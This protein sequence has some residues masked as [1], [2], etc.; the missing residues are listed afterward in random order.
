MLF[1]RLSTLLLLATAA[2]AQRRVEFNRDVRPILSDKC[3]LCHGPDAV[4]RKIPLRLDSEAAAK[5]DLGNRRAIVE[6]NPKLSGL[7]HRITAEKTA[8]RM[9]P[10]YSGLKLSPEEV[11][12]LRTWIAQGARWEK[13]WAFNPPRRAEPPAVKQRGWVRNPIDAFIL[14]R[15]ERAA[16]APSSEAAKETLLRRVSLDLTGVA[17]SPDEM[18]A[19]L[20]DRSANAYEKAVDRLLGS[21]RYGER[22]AARWLDAA[23]YADT[24]GYQYD[25]ERVMWRWRDWV[26][27]AFNRNQRFDQFT[28][29]QVAGDLLPARRLDQVIATGFNRNHRGNTEDGIIP[30]EYRVEYVVDRVETTSTVFLGLTLGCAR[31]HNHK[32]DPFTQKEFYQLFAYFNNVPEMGRAMKYGNSPPLVPAPTADQEG[33]Q[34]RLQQRID[35]LERI[36]NG[37]ATPASWTE[38]AHWRLSSGLDA[39]FPFDQAENTTA[40]VFDKAGVFDGTAAP[41]FAGVA[42]YDIGD[43]FTLSA[44]VK[45][46]GAGGAPPANGA[47]VSRMADTARGKGIGLYLREGKLHFHITS[48]YNDDAIRME[49]EGK[50]PAGDWHHVAVTYNGSVAASGAQFYIDGRA[51]KAV[52]SQDTLYRPFRNAGSRF[53]EPFLIGAGGGKENRFRGAIDEVLL[54]GRAL[55]SEEVEAVAARS[56]TP[57]SSRLRWSYLSTDAP[58]EIR[59]AWGELHRVRREK[60][61]LERS[62]PTVMVMGEMETPRQTHLLLRGAYDKPGEAVAS[63][64]P[65]SL[66]K[67]PAGAP[68]NRLGLAQWLISK[69]NPLMARVTVNRF[70]QMYFGT[71][72]VKT[73]EDF[74]VQGEWP[75]HPELLD[76]LAT[77]FVRTGWD[78]KAMQKLIVTS[79]TYRQSSKATPELIQKDPENRLLARMSRVRL[80]AEMIRDQMLHAAGLLSEKIGGPSVKP[81]QP[82]GLWKELTMQDSDYV[83][84]QGED[85]YRRSLYTFWKRTVSPPMMMN[86]DSSMRE[87]CTVRESRTNTPL[88]ALNLMNDVTFLEAARRVGERMMRE[89]GASPDQ[90]LGYGFRLLLARYPAAEE[91]KILAGSLSYHLDYFATKPERVDAYLTQGASPIAAGL[92]RRELAAYASVASLIVN[93]DEAVNR[94]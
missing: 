83:L 81:Y 76:W 63:G 45:P 10:A 71:G 28:L 50:V 59:E 94:E 69:E 12:T 68:A 19:F 1:L 41:E 39:W 88:Q 14:A 17:P 16:L 91:R 27:D 29:E 22:M 66:H 9:P 85:L 90:R 44:W 38:T 13:H 78:V 70:W 18:D 65:E 67:M 49:S 73:V 31:C 26:I 79:A 53:R 6:G 84:S 46:E 24:N 30:E 74:G 92:D 51:V 15:L 47:I 35:A 93:L 87:S 40:G 36:V 3:F 77:E 55:S 32:Y 34:K 86:F 80:P 57:G 21:P 54:Y 72:L 52:V 56:A 8:V 43:H 5:A 7:M 58:L 4:N 25:G 33:A 11:E 20:K 82:D 37:H 64:V 89:G 75:T 23:R 62:F 60:E 48:N 61:K 2:L 42:A